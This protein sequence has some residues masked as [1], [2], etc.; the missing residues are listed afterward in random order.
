LSIQRDH[1]D[2]NLVV[3]NSEALILIFAFQFKEALKTGH[4]LHLFFDIVKGNLC[5]LMKRGVDGLLKF[6]FLEN[7]L[8]LNVKIGIYIF[9]FNLG[10][11][12]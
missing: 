9:L 3:F 8:N 4:F 10:H 12:F 1:V 7:I 6:T 5:F 11:F 2:Q